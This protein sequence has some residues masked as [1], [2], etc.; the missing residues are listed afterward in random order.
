MQRV[1]L[2]TELV[3]L[4]GPQATFQGLQELAITTIQKEFS[5]VVTIIGTGSRKSLLFI[6]PAAFSTRVTIVIVPL[7]SLRQNMLERCNHLS[8]SYIE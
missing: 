1:N 4:L 6:L 7:V 5:P 8:I 3:K 2:Q